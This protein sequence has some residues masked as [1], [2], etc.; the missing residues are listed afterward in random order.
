MRSSTPKLQCTLIRAQIDPVQA[1]SN[2][3]KEA[4]HPDLPSPSPPSQLKPNND[5]KRDDADETHCMENYCSLRYLI[6]L[7]SIEPLIPRCHVTRRRGTSRRW[8]RAG[9]VL[10][11]QCRANH[12][13]LQNGVQANFQ[14]TS[15]VAD[16]ACWGAP[17]ASGS[18]S[19]GGGWQQPSSASA[20]SS[21]HNLGARP[22]VPSRQGGGWYNGEINKYPRSDYGNP[23]P[24]TSPFHDWGHFSQMV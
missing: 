21:R 7:G 22:P 1:W 12:P 2:A 6:C 16:H 24:D 23:K 8:R 14:T 18:S 3:N 13:L 15:P 9:N 17:A 19:G 20:S 4:G 5:H 11:G 10:T